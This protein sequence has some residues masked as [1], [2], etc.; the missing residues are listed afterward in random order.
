M[1]AEEI[2]IAKSQ[3]RVLVVGRKANGKFVA[4]LVEDDGG[5][6]TTG[7][8]GV[9]ATVDRE[10]PTAAVPTDADANGAVPATLA[11][12]QFW[13]GTAWTR[14]RTGTFGGQLVE[15]ADQP[16]AEDNLNGVIAT[17]P[18]PFPALT[19]ENGNPAVCSRFQNR[20]TLATALVK[21]SAGKVY[22]VSCTNLNGSARYVQLH[23]TAAALTGGEAPQASFLVE[24]GAQLV[25]GAEW[26][27]QHG[28]GFTT[29]I[30]WAFSTTENTY[31][32]GA[33]GDQSSQVRFI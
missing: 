13:T 28:E 20:G 22:A 10:L 1:A 4:V 2:D 14:A 17:G 15:A 23:N 27:T 24:A 12:A 11:R 18:A 5:V 6:T 29:G 16:V 19:F 21:G 30:T 3:E 25:L 7:G 31:T 9:A 32:A 33:A 8:G 26:F